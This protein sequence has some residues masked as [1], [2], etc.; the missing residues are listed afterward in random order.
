MEG[1]LHL[2]A[3]SL[4]CKPS[5]QPGLPLHSHILTDV[6]FSFLL[7]RSVTTSFSSAFGFLP[8]LALV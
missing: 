2:S 4:C 6:G 1:R 8:L 7:T 5:T 3:S